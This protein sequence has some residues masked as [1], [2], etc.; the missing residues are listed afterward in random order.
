MQSFDS[1]PKSPR[2]RPSIANGHL[3]TA[4]HAGEVFMNGL[5]NGRGEDSHRAVIPSTVSFNITGTEPPS[6]FTRIYTLNAGEGRH[7]HWLHV[8][9]IS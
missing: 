8:Y 3:G 6:N 5:Y 1:L 7:S 4:V 2:L 9:S